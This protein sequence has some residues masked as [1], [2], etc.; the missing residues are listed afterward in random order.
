MVRPVRGAP[1][2]LRRAQAMMRRAIWLI[3][4]AMP[5]IMFIVGWRV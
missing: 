5:V 4:V 3:A 2:E 1:E